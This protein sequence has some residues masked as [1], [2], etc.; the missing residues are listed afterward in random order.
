MIGTESAESGR[1]RRLP[2]EWERVL[3]GAE[4]KQRAL[5]VGLLMPGLFV[6]ELESLD[7]GL[8]WSWTKAET[9]YAPYD[10]YVP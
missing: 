5:T 3:V 8:T 10:V 1:S 2:I 9:S 7:S 6:P 4:G